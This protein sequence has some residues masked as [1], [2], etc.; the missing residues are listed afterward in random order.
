MSEYELSHAEFDR[1]EASCVW[2]L[3][4]LYTLTN[5]I[6][7]GLYLP[8]AYSPAQKYSKRRPDLEAL[9]GVR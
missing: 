8:L 1:A 2:G 3:L 5:R 7:G 4:P 9:R 6:K